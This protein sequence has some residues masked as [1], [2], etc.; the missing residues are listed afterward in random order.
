MELG[1]GDED[2]VIQELVRIEK[3]HVKDRRD[4]S[5]QYSAVFEMVSCLSVWWKTIFWVFICPNF[6]WLSFSKTSL[7]LSHKL[8]F[9]D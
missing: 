1:L 4:D 6:G 2:E 7:R 5:F 9:P 3:A 8:F